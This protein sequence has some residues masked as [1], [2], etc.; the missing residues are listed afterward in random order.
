MDV[1]VIA[2]TTLRRAGDV[3]SGRD[4]VVEVSRRSRGATAERGGHMKP[5]EDERRRL[6]A[7]SST[8]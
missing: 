8:R 2:S 3:N 6:G 4:A 1:L 5:Y 7:P